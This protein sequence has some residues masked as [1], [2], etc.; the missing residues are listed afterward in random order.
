M[1]NAPLLVLLAIA[2]IWP[3]GRDR[4]RDKSDEPTGT[5]KDLE[6]ADVEVDTRRGDRRRRSEGDGELSAVPRCRVRRSAAAR[7]RRCGGSRT[8]SSR[9]PTSRSSRAT[10]SRSG[11]LGGTIEM[12]EQLARVVSELRQER[13]RALPARARLRG[14]RAHRRLAGDARSPDRAVPADRASR[15]SAVPARRDAVRAEA[16]SRC[17]ARLRGRA[18]GRRRLGVLRAGALQA[19]L[20][21]VQAAAS[22]KTA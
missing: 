2:A 3:F 5:I 11:T 20:G 10:S 7:P 22:T 9:R 17:G 18:R 1:S 16:L 4:D 12:Y 13:S 19:R 15:R 6:R 14:R 8:C 21:A